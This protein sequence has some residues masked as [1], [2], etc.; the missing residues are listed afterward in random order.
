MLRLKKWRKMAQ[1]NVIGSVLGTSG[2]DNH[3][4]NLAN[5]LSKYCD[6][7]LTTNAPPGSENMLTDKELGMIKRL[8]TKDEINLIITHPTWWRPYINESNKRNWVFMVW[9][10]DKIPISFMDECLNPDIEK[11]LV[12]STHTRDAIINTAKQITGFWEAVNKRN[13][14]YNKI[15]LAPHGVDLEMF[16]PKDKPKGGRFKFMANKGF[17]N[18]E[19]RG[20]LQ[21]LLQAYVEEFTDKDNVELLVK[22]NPA[23]GIPNMAQVLTN[24][25]PRKVS[26]PMV[27]VNTSNIDQKS[28]VNLYNDAHCFVSPTRA[29]SYNLPCMEAMACGLPVITS[30]FGGQ[31]DFVNEENG[32]IIPGKLTEQEHDLQYEGI[33]WLTPDVTELRRVMRWVYD[34][35]DKIEERSKK[36]LETARNNTWDKTAKT[37]YTLIN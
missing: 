13:E 31:T 21:Y 34:N 30:G 24:I 11:I 9:E 35:Q 12:P 36:A 16:Y 2:Y 20:G 1:I 14:L 6:V 18:M 32:W 22:I 37:I 19:D 28:L 17:R 15:V 8:P 7:R 25:A 4:R 10:G 26:I 33:K 3:T 23:Y 29:E 5:A 27:T